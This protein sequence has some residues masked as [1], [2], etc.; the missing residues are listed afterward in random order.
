MLIDNCWQ[1]DPM[2][3][4]YVEDEIAHVELVQRTLENNLQDGFILRNRD[5][6]NGALEVLKTEPDID[7][8]L[9][10]LRL[11]D[12]SG[13]DLL[14]IIREMKMPPA[15]VL[16]TGQGDQEVAVTALKA[17]AADYLVKQSDYLHRLPV[18]ISNAVAQNRLLREQAA[19]REAE[20][21]YQSLVEQTPAVVFLD[22]ADENETTIYINPR[23][24]ELTGFSPEEW[25]SDSF[26]WERNIHPDDQKR[27][28]QADQRTHK[29][30][31]RFQ[32]EYRLIRRDGRVVWIKEDTNLVH[33][34]DGTPLYWLGI[35]I[36]ITKE[37]DNEAAL[38]RQL[39]E[40]TVLHSITVAGT[41]GDFEDE[42]IEKV[43]QITSQ[44][45]DEVCGVLLLNSVG[46]T[47]T[48]H[49]SYFGAD[50]SKWKIG[51]P[52][53]EGVTG[54]SV[55]LG[56]PQR[57]DD[58]TREAEYIEIASGIR[59]ELCVPIRVS[60][61]IIG[62]LNVES[63]R[64]GAYDKEDEQFINTVAASLGT[65]LER[66]RLFKQEKQR[67]TELNTLYQTTK[68]LTRSLKP[69]VIAQN[70][71]DSLEDMIGYKF[72]GVVGIDESTQLL[73]PLAI[74]RKDLTEEA[75]QNEMD[76]IRN[77]NIKVGQGITGW[78]IQNSQ[79]IRIGNAQTDPRY[80][81][82]HEN[83][84]SL[85]CV[86][87][88]TRDRT[89]G[90]VI[91]ESQE[92]DAYTDHDESLLVAL[93]G[94]A[95]ITLE[96][97]RLYEAQRSRRKEAEALR[98]ATASLS[99][100]IELN[101]LLDQILESILKIIP[102]DSA[103]I[104]LENNTG[105][106]E[107]VAA[108]GFSQNENIV[109]KRAPLSAKWNELSE[110]HK[111]LIIPDAQTDPRFEQMEGSEK[112]RGW[113]SVPMIAQE[114]IIGFINLDSH[115]VNA[116]TERDATLA[117][118]FA[119]SAAAAILIAKL[120]ISQREQFIREAA[121]LN[122]MRSAASSLDLDQVLHTILDQLTKLLRAEAGSIQLFED[123]HLL[124]AATVGFDGKKYAPNG[125][126]LMQ[127]FPLDQLAITSQ[128]AI[129]ID[130]VLED[131]RWVR[132]RGLDQTRSFLLIPLIS[133]G[134]S[135]GLITL[136]HSI[137]SYFTDRDMEISVAIAN[138]ASIAIENARLYDEAQNRLRE[139]E[140]I[141]HVS[142]SLRTTQLQTDMIDILLDEILKLLK[143]ENGAIWLYDNPSGMLIRRTTRGIATHAK[144]NSMHPGEGIVGNVFQ[145]GNIHISTDLI[146]DPLLFKEDLDIIVPGYKGICI[147]IQST[148]GILGTLTIQ[149][150]SNRPLEG[151]VNLL[152]TLA[153]IAGNSI[154]RA[155]L[156][157]QSREQ[158]HK[159]TTL[160]DIDSAIASSTDLRVT[161]N[162]LTD[163]A[164]KH[165]KVDAVDI[166]LYHPELQSITYLTSAGF[167]TPSPS[168]P[169]MRIGEGLAGQVVMKGRIDHVTDMQNLSEV[170][171]D[172]MLL[173]ERFV[174]YIGVPLVVKGQVKGVF[175]VFN[176][177][178]LVPNEEWMQFLQTL[179]GQ[180]AIAIDNSQLFDNLQRSN[181]ELTQAYDTTLEG[182]ARALEL[183]DRETEG[184]TRRV[185]EL[186]TRLARFMNIS[187]DDL[188]N[189]YRGVLL[190]DIGKMGVPDQILRKTGPLTDM[191][192]GEMRQHPQYAFNL[193]APIPYLRFAL[194]IPYCHHEHWDGS[195]YP[196]GLKGEQ[197]PLSARI[198][199]IV[200]IWDAL[201]SD[202]PYRK[203]WNRERVIK[204]LQ[205]ISGKIL[206]PAVVK[207]FL[208]MI[209]E[210]D[211]KHKP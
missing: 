22:A 151:Y 189:I 173:R 190:H 88:S 29:E 118:T 85:L 141:N 211:K 134:V 130:D 174:A 6:L 19:L 180:A 1:I 100:H 36:D 63:R 98:E 106:M 122:L 177:T 179:A 187:E 107:I 8:V 42:I 41:E 117:Q 195:G 109:G 178:P 51:T 37:K 67:A 150:E 56:V 12:G 129:N 135:I 27:I 161:L 171:S 99:V 76:F 188:V 64:I 153:E 74:S 181:Q 116:Y 128:K 121:I 155:E 138:H 50:T 126:V 132:I 83:V 96:N 105:N 92:M 170:K 14:K 139:M 40:L 78:V 53:T 16:V 192:W 165:L 91:V 102:F 164:I 112:I 20:I 154:H 120:F 162:I 136:D 168:R 86:P 123:D 140:T 209:S 7:L 69:K 55:S 47:L 46:D 204:Y 202:R 66:L 44:I 103:S 111:A 104:F 124:V 201:L 142:S 25:Q 68:S 146:N 71:L 45:Y 158:I 38:Q 9:T 145:T 2:K 198:F 205:E 28:K 60:R 149:M 210:D 196:R 39:K 133:K 185:T 183:R 82:V 11:P 35:L 148:V 54:K 152:T 32:E 43:V 95:A 97:A 197:I 127:D 61:R 147:P 206:D 70:L 31:G 62:V 84:H 23:V 30:G 119:N 176:R 182:W 77:L 113:M 58:V 169:T 21:R 89:I 163:H 73:T 125:I 184:H 59:S 186:T 156:F 175:E 110:S 80:I 87:L 167:N 49:S 10:D 15:V 193:L 3:I 191:E 65:A 157:E 5:S 34:K 199:S 72:S 18:V 52:I 48:P 207:A 93:A 17:G 200:D 101:P 114:R 194:D 33:D 166:L 159:L 160:R 13:L 137:P 172:P 24:E 203:A 144:N 79:P 108:K 81:P 208:G 57:I 75:Y 115:K 90:A 4:L 143:A 94:S 26:I 131:N